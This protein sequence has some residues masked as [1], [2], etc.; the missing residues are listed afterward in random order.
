MFDLSHVSS[1]GIIHGDLTTSNML[2]S[3]TETSTP[4][5][6]FI[7]FGLSKLSVKSSEQHAVDLYVLERA[8]RSTLSDSDALFNSILK[9]YKSAFKKESDA[10]VNLKRFAE[11]RMRGR[12]RNM[13]G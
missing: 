3:P 10:E 11:V 9:G 12:K 6:K 4:I 8:I 13:V 2:I 1:P 5:L 7:D